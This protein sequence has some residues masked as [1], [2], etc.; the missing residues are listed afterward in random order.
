MKSENYN[1]LGVMSGT[2]LDG[3][4][5]AHV[6]LS[7]LGDKWS[8]SIHEAETVPYPDEWVKKLKEAVNYTED[9]LLALDDA[10]TVFLAGVISSFIAKHA[11]QLPD[12]VC[13]HGHTVLHQ[14]KKG[15]T[16]QIGNKPELAKLTGL[17]VV[18]NYRVQDVQLGGQG[19]PLVP[20]GDRLLFSNYD[21]CL[22]LGGFSNISFEDNGNRIAYDISPVNTVLNY[23]ANRLGLP[24]DDGGAIARSG[25]IVPSLLDALN[26][27]DYYKKSYPKSLGFEYVRD[28]VLPLMENSNAAVPEKLRTFTTHVAMQLAR[29]I[30]GIKPAGKLLV[31]GGGAYNNFLIAQLKAMLPDVAVVIPDD[32]TIQFKEALIFA[33]LG[34]LRLR[35]EINVLASVTGAPHNHSA[36]FVFK[37]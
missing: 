26:S 2:S 7:V 9:A 1:V 16:L 10:Y 20:V 23:Y 35:G 37:P 18:C 8:Y 24:Y 28:V 14:P 21:F 12:A 36:G 17:K 15:V 34:T 5:L 19:A 30:L 3:I 4:D 32:K 6:T 11:L 22:N 25:S 13:S 29:E 27:L 31:T 33:L